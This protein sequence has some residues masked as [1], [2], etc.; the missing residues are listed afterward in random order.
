MCRIKFT[1]NVTPIQIKELRLLTEKQEQGKDGQVLHL[2]LLW[3]KSMTKVIYGFIV[4][5][6]WF[7][8]AIYICG[9]CVIFYYSKG[10]FLFLFITDG[11]IVQAKRESKSNSRFLDGLESN[12]KKTS[13]L[14]RQTRFDLLP[15]SVPKTL[16]GSIRD[17]QSDA[18]CPVFWQM[19]VIR[20]N[21]ENV[22]QNKARMILKNKDKYASD[23]VHSTQR[24]GVFW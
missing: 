22:D 1:A 23:Q 9:N 5:T 15:E 10:Y 2:F 24:N 6:P 20:K 12:V 13:Y 8:N 19:M 11:L 7:L 21:H 4:F 18:R 17:Y 14:Q 16:S 3:K